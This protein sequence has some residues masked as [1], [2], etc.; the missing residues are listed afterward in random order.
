MNNHGKKQ[1]HKIDIVFM[2][3]NPKGEENPKKLPL[4]KMY[5]RQ[6]QKQVLSSLCSVSLSPMHYSSE[7]VC[8]QIRTTAPLFI[9][10]FQLTLAL[11]K[12]APINCLGRLHLGILKN[13]I[14][15]HLL[16]S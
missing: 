1:N 10:I 7:W 11:E 15:Y 6:P 8:V 14:L 3:G 16:G 12:L 2:L 13:S 4:Y 5:K 9:H